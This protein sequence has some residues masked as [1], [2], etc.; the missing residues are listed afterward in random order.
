MA[1]FIDEISR[2]NV[3]QIFG[4]LISLIE[5]DKRLGARHE[6]M[7]ELPGSRRLFGVPSNVW[8]IGTMNTA[9]RSVVALD[10]ALRRRFAFCECPPRPE[11]L[12]GVVVEGVDLEALL[13]AVNDRILRLRDRD[14]LIGHAFFMGMADASG[15][16]LDA[17]RRVFRESI[18]V[19]KPDLLVRLGDHPAPIVMDTK[20]KVPG[21]DQP[22]DGDLRQLFAY[23]QSFGA[24]RG[25][26]L[27]PRAHAEQRDANGIFVSGGQRGD[28]V[29]LDLFRDGAPSRE[30][31]REQLRALVATHAQE[32][33]A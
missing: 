18:R 10:T 28:V 26:L 33:V 1:V 8:I 22:S 25:V 11:L 2:G 14:H 13:V 31:V 3:A 12:R 17:L 16:T 23:V 15:R 24:R 7:V 29:F 5:P 30:A 21:N 6:M 27:Y 20:W 32:E 4:E 9:D 19:A